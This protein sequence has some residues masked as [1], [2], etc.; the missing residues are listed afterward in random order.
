MECV[1]VCLPA[2]FSVDLSSTVVEHIFRSCL[3]KSSKTTILKNCLTSKN[4]AFQVLLKL[5]YLL[6]GKYTMSRGTKSEYIDWKRKPKKLQM[7]IYGCKQIKRLYDTVRYQE[8]LVLLLIWHENQAESTV[9][10][11]PSSNLNRSNYRHQGVFGWI[12]SLHIR[13]H[14]LHN[15]QE[16]Q[17]AV[18]LE[19]LR[20]KIRA[21]HFMNPCVDWVRWSN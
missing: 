13:A 17:C 3:S 19:R 9:I 20:L 6:S 21:P 2:Y 8:C 1:S 10:S 7:N 18:Q 16:M 5:N 11:L 12:H 15:S 4:H 14:P